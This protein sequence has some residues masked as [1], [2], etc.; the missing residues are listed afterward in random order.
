MNRSRI[1]STIHRVANNK[2]NRPRDNSRN[3]NNN[4]PNRQTNYAQSPCRNKTQYSNSQSKNYRRSTPNIKDKLIKYNQQK[5]PIQTLPLLPKLKTSE[6][7]QLNHI[8]YETTD[9]KKTLFLSYFS[10]LE[11]YKRTTKIS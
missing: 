3:Q 10:D 7:M 2:N 4:Y 8:H 9:D 6:F 1:T 5:K 11:T